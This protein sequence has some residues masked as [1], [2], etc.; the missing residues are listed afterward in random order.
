MTHSKR[1]IENFDH[2]SENNLEEKMELKKSR[3]R[4]SFLNFDDA[5]IEEEK[6][7]EE[8]PLNQEHK[9]KKD[10]TKHLHPLYVLERAFK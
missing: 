9:T 7:T 4:G 2:H 10:K 6:A 5:D 3:K 8:K 1:E